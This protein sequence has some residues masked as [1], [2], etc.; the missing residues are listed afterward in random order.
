M[1]TA[2]PAAAGSPE[3]LID[4][5]ALVET[6]EH[7]TFEFEIA[8]PFQRFAAYL[9]DFVVR[10]LLLAVFAFLGAFA[11]GL[12]RTWLG[13][14]GSASTGALLLG[15]FAI[16]WLYYVICEWQFNGRTPGKAWFGLRVVR[17]GGQPIT[18]IDAVL[19]NLLRAADCLPAPF[20]MVGVLVSAADPR[21]RRLGDLVADTMVVVDRSSAAQQAAVPQAVQPGHAADLPARLTLPAAERRTL[22]ALVR[23]TRAIGQARMQEICRD[24]TVQLAERLGVAPPTDSVAF[25]HAVYAR[26]QAADR[27]PRGRP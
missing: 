18:G 23:R 17:T 20:Y 13:D 2:S 12:A 7:L 21:F 4:A 22:D 14:L 16:E 19:R 9:V 1:P 11:V 27:G 24:Y 10:C 26:L 8:G 3:P 6:P 25:V 5:T 15:W